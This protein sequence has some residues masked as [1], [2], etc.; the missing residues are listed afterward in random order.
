MKTDDQNADIE[1]S[2]V[3]PCL[4]EAETIAT[5]IRK[6]QRFIEKHQINAEIIVSDNGSNDGS[7]LIAADNGA[8]V[9]EVKDRGYGSSLYGG[10]AI[11][12]GKY[13]IMG[14][15]DDSYDFSALSPFIEKLREGYDLVMG[16]RLPIGGGQIMP[17]A[18][19]FKH[20]YFGNPVLSFIGKLFFRSTTT[21]FH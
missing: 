20:R 6:T 16:C 15:A 3:M 12:R 2:I 7:Q 13:I 17:G 4:N 21:D 8:K 11:A 9:V 1:F 10:I 5:C 14:D 19:P 18:M